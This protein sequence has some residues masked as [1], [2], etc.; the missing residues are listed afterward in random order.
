MKN[1]KFLPLVILVGVVALL[2][3]LLAVLTLHGKA[4]TDTT[5]PLCD[6]AAD[7]IDALS[8]AGNNVEVSLLKGSDGWLLAD[9]AGPDQGAEP[10]GGLRQPEGAAQARG[11]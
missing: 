4:E 3:I 5:L 8:Y 1:K 10:C 9:D 11:R 6:L 2:G 7:D